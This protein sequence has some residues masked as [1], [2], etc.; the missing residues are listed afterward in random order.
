MKSWIRKRRKLIVWM[1]MLI[2]VL[3]VTDIGPRMGLHMTEL[4]EARAL[5]KSLKQMAPE[6]MALIEKE[7]L[8]AN[9][10]IILLEESENLVGPKF[11]SCVDRLVEIKNKRAEIIETL[12]QG[13]LKPGAGWKNAMTFLEFKGA[14][15]QIG[16][17]IA[18]TESWIEIALS[19]RL[20]YSL[21]SKAGTKGELPELPKLKRQLAT[22]LTQPGEE[23]LNEQARD[24]LETYNLHPAELFQE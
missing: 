6:A 1:V 16:T 13:G 23:P 24:L 17:E 8:V 15:D 4:A 18:R 20:R 10:L 9:E 7:H 22:Y 12:K 3:Y 19:A 21:R 11:S 5:A 2:P 14:L